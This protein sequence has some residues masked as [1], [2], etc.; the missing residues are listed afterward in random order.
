MPGAS[1]VTLALVVDSYSS[2]QVRG[3]SPPIAIGI[4]YEGMLIVHAVTRAPISC[5]SLADL[6][7][8]KV[9]RA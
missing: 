5:H 7:D 2:V 8:W 4:G 1:T 9:P 6:S 3:H